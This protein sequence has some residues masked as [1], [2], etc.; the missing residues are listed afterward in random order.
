ML[1]AGRAGRR[2]SNFACASAV[3]PR[4][5]KPQGTDGL[6]AAIDLSV[7]TAEKEGRHAVDPGKVTRQVRCIDARVQFPGR[8]HARFGLVRDGGLELE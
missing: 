4:R 6:E 8:G 3:R 1:E 7:D 5:P 2:W